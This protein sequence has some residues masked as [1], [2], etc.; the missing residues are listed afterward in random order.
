[1]N[2]VHHYELDFEIDE[3]L[4]ENIS[5]INLIDMMTF[6]RVDFEKV[7]NTKSK[8]KVKI[9]SKYKQEIVENLLIQLDIKYEIFAQNY[10]SVDEVRI[11]KIRTARNYQS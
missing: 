6:D 2:D 8:K 11:M 7:V 10:L 4:K 1:M 3:T 5:R 9:E